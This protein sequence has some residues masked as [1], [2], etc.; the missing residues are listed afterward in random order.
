MYAE[1]KID[2]IVKKKKKR[3]KLHRI[4]MIIISGF[5]CIFSLGFGFGVVIG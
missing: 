2:E 1:I 5:V 3:Q 4:I